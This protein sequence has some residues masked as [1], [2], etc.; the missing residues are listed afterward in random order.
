MN[1]ME[2]ELAIRELVL[3]PDNGH[4]RVS[5]NKRENIYSAQ[6]KHEEAMPLYERAMP[7]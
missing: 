3:G 1:K 7:I 4:L 2:D 6:R 5:L